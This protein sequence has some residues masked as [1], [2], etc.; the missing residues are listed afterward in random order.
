[1]SCNE[2]EFTPLVVCIIT[3]VILG[4]SYGALM[5]AV[6]RTP[7]AYETQYKVTI[8]EEVTM[9][10]FLEHYEVIDQDG[11]IFT[12]REKDKNV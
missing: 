8:S 5:G 2:M 4:C 11:K 7:T 9:A 10:E 12:V 6:F 3:G 1:M